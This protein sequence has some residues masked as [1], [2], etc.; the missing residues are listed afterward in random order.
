MLNISL[1][2]DPRLC[3]LM[4]VKG[5][6]PGLRDLFFLYG[7]SET[8]GDNRSLIISTMPLGIDSSPVQTD[9]VPRQGGDSLK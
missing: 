7:H 5:E 9:S 3:Y 2:N 6:G 4:S 8:Q 1:D